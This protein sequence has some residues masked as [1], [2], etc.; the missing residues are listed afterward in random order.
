M[1]RAGDTSK[2]SE[3]LLHELSTLPADFLQS[4]VKAAYINP[5]EG[6]KQLLDHL[7]GK[8]ETKTEHKDEPATNFG[9][10]RWHAEQLGGAVGSMVPYFL[11]NK[12]VARLGFSK[13]LAPLATGMLMEGVLRPVQSGEDFN[14]AR[15][16]NALT[17]GLTFGTLGHLPGYLKSRD[18]K[19]F[20]IEQPWLVNS[21]TSELKRH[22]ISGAASGV[23][24]IESRSILS[25]HGVNINAQQIA[26]SVYNY[27]ALGGFMR[28]ATEIIPAATK[29]ASINDIVQNS[30]YLRD[31]AKLDPVAK[32]LLYKHGDS[33]IRHGDRKTSKDI[34]DLF[35]HANVPEAIAWKQQR[36]NSPA[37]NIS[38]ELDFLFSEFKPTENKA[39]P[40]SEFLAECQQTMNDHPEAQIHPL[41]AY[42]EAMKNSHH[43]ATKIIGVGIDSLALQLENGDVLKLSFKLGKHQMGTR[44]Y[45]MPILEQG[46]FD[47]AELRQGITKNPNASHWD[48]QQLIKLNAPNRAINYLIQPK[49][50]LKVPYE[51]QRHFSNHMSKL[52]D[53]F[54]DFGRTRLEQLGY[55]DGRIV[56]IDYFAVEPKA[57]RKAI[58][59]E[60]DTRPLPT[61][62]ED[63]TGRL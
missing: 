25:G 11:C 45:D 41:A 26:Q 15:T 1:S 24:D 51:I 37:S 19:R 16:V 31:R 50:E 34:Y 18:A 5:T 23:V 47:T 52:G 7:A 48:R 13:I 30:S 60:K 57:V 39:L 62:L 38:S 55:F 20:A 40:I 3:T 28:G 54:W 53:V 14:Q 9:S 6:A 29:G 43:K 36:S 33:R 61:K 10:L 12:V 21:F 46:Q 42:R 35:A 22:V 63:A 8:Q 56:L 2:P 59:D 27:G 32:E 58:E 17:G 4:A 49:A 44:S